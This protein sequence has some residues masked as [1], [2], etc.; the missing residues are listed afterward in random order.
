MEA[1][2]STFSSASVTFRM[3]HVSSNT[4]FAGTGNPKVHKGKPLL[5]SQVSGAL[6][7]RSRVKTGA[8]VAWAKART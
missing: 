7:L 1:C 3:R 2:S 8:P 6:R 5:S 4:A